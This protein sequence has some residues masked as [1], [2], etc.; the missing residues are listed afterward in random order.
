MVGGDGEFAA[1][2]PFSFEVALAGQTRFRLEGV[3]GN[4]DVAASTSANT[5][6]IA[7]VRRVT[8][9]SA[10]DAQAGLQ[11]LE[12]RVSEGPDVLLVRTIQPQDSGDRDYIV[13]YRIT[14][15]RNLAVIVNNVNGNIEIDSINNRVTVASV[16]GGVDLRR[17]VGSATVVLVNGAIEGRITLPTD[18]TIDLQTVNGAIDLEIPQNT[19]ARFSASVA[20]GT[21]TVSNLDLRVSTSTPT[22]V[23]GTL[24]GGRGTIALLTVNGTI[25]VMGF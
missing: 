9:D 18:G 23:E 22:S 25:E 11:V 1:E 10:E 21:V 8:S 24:G 5:I 14:L 16:N 20:N 4:V 2:E 17:I 15:P 13:N 6:V 3:S 7:G 12:V 19:S